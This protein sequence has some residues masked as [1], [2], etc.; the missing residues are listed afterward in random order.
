M[1][2]RSKQ[3]EGEEQ[4][5]SSTEKE[6]GVDTVPDIIL[7]ARLNNLTTVAKTLASNFSDVKKSIDSVSSS[8]RQRAEQQG[9]ITA[10]EN[11]ELEAQVGI[12]KDEVS[13]L[14]TTLFE[15]NSL[16][17]KLVVD[18]NN[19]NKHSKMQTSPKSTSAEMRLSSTWL[20]Q[21]DMSER[22]NAVSYGFGNQKHKE[23]KKDK[24]PTFKRQGK[25]VNSE[26]SSLETCSSSSGGG[27]DSNAGIESEQ[28]SEASKGD[29]EED[30]YNHSLDNDTCTAMRKSNSNEYGQAFHS[31]ITTY[32]NGN[33]Y[34]TES[35]PLDATQINQLKSSGN[36]VYFS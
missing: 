27:K 21:S 8:S 26:D 31:F 33:R 10:R 4:V 3:K 1:K 17:K 20:N 28:E 11:S 12:L 22:I 14:K 16:L 23:S 30:S 6:S 32:A 9:Q 5:R 25:Q 24:K 29:M 13:S 19:N 15:I 34:K 18:N 35:D 7:E 2:L 36:L